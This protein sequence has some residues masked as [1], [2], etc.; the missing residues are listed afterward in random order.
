MLRAALGDGPEAQA[1]WLRWQSGHASGAADAANQRLLPLV[2]Y[3][4]SKCG[5]ADA[6]LQGLRRE[7]I[8]TQI[9]NRAVFVVLDHA[10]QSLGDAGIACLLLKGAALSVDIYQDMGLRPMSDLDVAVPHA[11]A[12]RAIE[13]LASSGWVLVNP[14]PCPRPH[15]TSAATFQNAA[16]FEFDLHFSPFHGRLSWREVAPLWSAAKPV[17]VNGKAAFVL[18]PADQLLHTFSHGARF[19]ALPSIRWVADATW[20][21]RQSG[22][23]DWDAFLERAGGLK[24]ALVS[25]RMLAYLKKTHALDVPSTV[26]LGLRRR[27]TAFEVL[28]LA[29]RRSLAQ[30]YGG[31]VHLARLG[32]FFLSH[33]ESG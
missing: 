10:L 27:V 11:C 29:K 28:E 32:N 19:N 30:R 9:R 1:A 18:S 2:H 21:M 23:V 25:W 16:G 17:S 3:N 26:L 4:L 5:Y 33:L 6:S 31:G 8:Q 7:R 15:E 14:I 22:G 13:V 24:L 20:I 12:R